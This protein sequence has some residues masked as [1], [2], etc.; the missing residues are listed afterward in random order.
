[1]EG[2]LDRVVAG[3]VVES[4]GYG[5]IVHLIL[6]LLICL[7]LLIKPRDSRTALLWIFFTSIFPFV[8]PFA[9]V[10]FGINTV[11]NKSWKKQYSDILFQQRQQR[12][13]RRKHPLAMVYERRNALRA[14]LPE[15]RLE[16]LNRVLDHCSGNHPL[17]GG[18]EIVLLEPAAVALEE[19]FL[20]MRQA[21][22]HIH[23]CTYIFGDGVIGQ[24]LMEL[25]VE[26][27]RAGVKVRVLYDAFGSAGPSLRRFFRRQCCVPNLELVAFSQANVFKRKFQF[28]LRNH[29]K[30]LIIDGKTAYTGGINFYDVYLPRGARPGVIDYHFRVRGPLVLELQYTFQRDWYYMTDQAAETLLERCYY[31]VPTAVGGIVARLQNSGPTR[32]EAAAALD[33]FLAAINLAQ[34]QILIVTPY[35]VPPEAL[36]LALRQAAFRGVEIK[37]LVPSENN[38]PT[39]KLASRAIYAKLLL[40][41]VRI[42]ERYP[43][44]IHAKAMVIDDRVAIIGSANFDNRS[45]FLNYETNLVVFDKPFAATLKSAI[46]DDL[47]NAEEIVYYTWRQRHWSRK[48]AEN[49]FNL[50]HPIA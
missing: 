28:G 13:R 17:L 35:F 49:F 7:H 19:M 39:L 36:I 14:T 50:F 5:T 33:A 43:P 1:M 32:D 16:P 46:L 41:N 20:S 23:L 15:P 2:A 40:A 18:N 42:Y 27:A 29:R 21:R 31:P 9:Y 47:A 45:L 48:L 4:L 6:W 8:G 10:L 37:V 25:L 12:S 34:K 24:R 44:F 22:H 30:L 38:Y 11:P 26:R 3:G